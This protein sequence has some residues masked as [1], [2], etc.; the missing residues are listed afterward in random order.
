MQ[1]LKDFDSPGFLRTANLFSIKLENCDFLTIYFNFLGLKSFQL[2]QFGQRPPGAVSGC[3][4]RQLEQFAI[5]LYQ[6]KTLFIPD[7]QSLRNAF[8]NL[9]KSESHLRMPSCVMLLYYECGDFFSR[10]HK[11]GFWKKI[12]PRYVLGLAEC[13]P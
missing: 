12:D 13:T 11:E 1:N 6:K 10:I 9:M 5:C 2:Q 7:C 8:V 3:I 4:L